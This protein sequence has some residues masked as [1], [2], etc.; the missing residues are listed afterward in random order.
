MPRATFLNLPESKRQ[1]LLEAA[2]AE[3]AQHDF[4]DALLDRIAGQ[5]RVPKGSLYQYFEDKRELY[6]HTVRDAMHATWGLF[7]AQLERAQPGDCL[8]LMREAMLH[9][10]W[11]AE[12]EP[13]LATLY[14]RVVFSQDT[15]ARAALFDSYLQHSDEFYERLVPWGIETGQIDPELSRE[16]I[17]FLIRGVVGQLQHAVLTGDETREAPWGDEGP[18]SFIDQLIALLSKALAPRNAASGTAR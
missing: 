11:L 6:V 13:V 14:A 4:A 9:M 17:R 10:V 1:R 2:R 7:E 16:V 8:Q 3:F 18:E 5:A 15:Y 12:H